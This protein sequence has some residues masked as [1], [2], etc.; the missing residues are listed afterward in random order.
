M[1]VNFND[2]DIRKNLYKLLDLVDCIQ[3]DPNNRTTDKEKQFLVEVLLLDAK[4]FGIYR[5]SKLAREEIIR[6]ALEYKNWKLTRRNISN[7]VKALNDKGLIYQEIDG[8][9]YVK[10]WLL[11]VALDIKKNHVSKEKY[12]IKFRFS[13]G[14]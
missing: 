2:S 1:V 9:Y 5:F 14:L 13:N 12:E 11:K 10:K 6:Q 3:P 8:E 7:K 4:Q